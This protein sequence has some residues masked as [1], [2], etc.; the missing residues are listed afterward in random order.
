MNAVL[1]ATAALA[2]VFGLGQLLIPVPLLGIF[3]VRLDT[4]AELFARAQGGA[5]LGYAVFNWL[6]RGSDAGAQRAAVLADLI[7]AVTGALISLYTLLVGNGNALI[8]VWVILFAAF[9]VWQA[10]VLW[11]PS[12]APRAG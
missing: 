5:Y 6:V 7:V 8:L 10:Y 11:R 3:G 1:T 2:L 12:P 4:T 9:A